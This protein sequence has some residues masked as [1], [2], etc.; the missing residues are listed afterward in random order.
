MAT[1]FSSTSTPNASP[2][3]G[4]GACSC[5]AWRSLDGSDVSLSAVAVCAAVFLVAS[6]I[7]G[8]VIEWRWA[9]NLSAIRSS[10][11][12]AASSL[13]PDIQF[14]LSAGGSVA[15]LVA[16]AT[17]LALAGR[18]VGGG[19]RR[20][21]FGATISLRRALGVVI[22]GFFVAMAVAYPVLWATA[23]IVKRFNPDFAAHEHSVID[24]IHSGKLAV[25][26]V[27]LLWIG[28]G[29]VAPLAE[30]T[31]FRGMAQSAVFRLFRRRGVGVVC[32][33]A[34]FGVAHA[35]LP[36][37]I[38]AMTTLG[39]VLGLAYEATDALIVPVSIHAL[40]NL[41]TLIGV[42]LGVA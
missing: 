3:A 31:F 15:Q 30:E 37:T 25:W 5:L 7:V 24:V 11:N 35:T 40:F 13:A 36:E 29:V 9:I 18:S 20:L 4:R 28:A 42:A 32:A 6:S 22:S 12:N 39:I 14:W 26:Q 21:M 34:L 19:V 16:L 2:P 27:G 10:G 1:L 8:R 41:A 38:P 17:C 33:S 23:W